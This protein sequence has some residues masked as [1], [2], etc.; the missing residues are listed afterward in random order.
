MRLLPIKKH[1]IVFESLWGR[2]FNDNPKAI[3]DYMSEKFG[4]KYK[5]VWFLNN[6]YTP[7][8][9]DVIAVRKNSWRYFYYLARG[10]YFV[11]NTN[12]PNFY[13]KRK[14]QIEMQTL[15]GTFMKTMGLDEKV[16]FNT[17]WKQE[18]LLKRS[19]RWDYL[20]SPSPYMTKTATSA[21]MFQHQVVECGF[22][23]ND[24]LYKHN[25]PDFIAQVKQE[26]NLPLDKKIV[27]YAP[28]FRSKDKFELHLDFDQLRERLSDHYILLLRLHYFVASRINV[29]AYKG[30]VYDVSSYPDIQNLY[31]IS[32][33]MI[34]DYSSVMFDY[35]HLKRPMLFFAYDLE[36]YRDDLRGMYLNYEETVPGPIVRSTEEII[37]HIQDPELA[38]KYHDKYVAFYN[39]F[40][41]FGRGD[42]ARKAAEQLLSPNVQ[43]QPGEPFIREYL[44]KK[45]RFV[46][47]SLFRRAGMLPRK[48]KT[49][50]FESFFG[51]QYSDNPR[52]IYEYMKKNYPDYHLVWNVK[53]GYEEIFK[54]ERVPY[55][56]KYSYR[57]IMQWARAKY[58]VT[59]SRWPLWLP[60]PKGT[61]YVQ[62]WHGTPLKTLGADIQ[63][64]TMPGMT[65]A[66]YHSQFTAE[67]R[68]WDYCVAPNPYSSKI[69]KRAFE[70]Q[71]QM[72]NS[73]YPRNDLLYQKNN[74]HDI[75]LIKKKLGIPQD[76]Q[77]I[78]YAPTW[79]DNEYKKIDHYTF[80]LK[81]DLERMRDTFG[82][83][84]VLLMR[85]HYLI[86]E[87]MDLS[88]YKDFAIDVSDYEDIRELYLVSDC[89][90]T[91]YSSVFFDYANLKRPIV[92][93]AYDLDD[94]ANE[95]RGF[96]FDFQKEAPGPIVKDMDHLIPSVKKALAYD[97]DNP[98]PE[99]YNK[100]CQWEDGHS[101]ERVVK[102]FL[103]DKH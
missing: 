76:K 1:V 65:L 39:K 77:V 59:N 37:R 54:R 79:R 101:T 45:F 38:A 52:A 32:D 91:D 25:N 51:Q 100:F 2:A 85:M 60:K 4:R 35:A 17:K 75:S 78:L 24:V 73:G 18:S 44:R 43:V 10:K 14:G 40:C 103:Q 72:I 12:F 31:L 80:D 3:Y 8:P 58:W 93:Y 69:F 84:A 5:Y 81:L 49:V 88:D 42:S 28:T 68:K 56:I 11:E 74:E 96:Y 6:E 57:G 89:L 30:F 53:K 64:I 20:V 95:I 48:P 33:M 16:T 41:T 15:H 46:Y 23:R 97:G 13:V 66:K 70:V 102:T 62:T 83:N 63:H 86:A 92:F 36:F 61:T 50:L 82:K 99:F 22:P 29:E 71:G 87:Q 34:T 27:L 90:I 94:Y 26:M 9:D 7:V 47:P 98:Y 55:V 21:F 19:G 67:A